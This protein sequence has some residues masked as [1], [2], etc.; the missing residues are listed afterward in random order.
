[1]Q[2]DV[3]YYI[4]ESD[5]RAVIRTVPVVIGPP[6]PTATSHVDR[7]SDAQTVDNQTSQSRR[8]RFKSRLAARRHLKSQS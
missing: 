8:E 7:G 6:A 5:D 1:M 3:R 2:K 4:S